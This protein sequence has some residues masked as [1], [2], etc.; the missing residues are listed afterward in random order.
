MHCEEYLERTGKKNSSQYIVRNI[1]K[2]LARHI[3][4]VL[5]FDVTTPY[6]NNIGRVSS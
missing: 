3:S 6:K 1:P 5:H 4:Q 2:E